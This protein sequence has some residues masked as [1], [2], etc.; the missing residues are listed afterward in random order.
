MRMLL[1]LI[2]LL[3]ALLVVAWLV[4]SQWYAQVGVGT[5]PSSGQEGDRSQSASAALR[6]F[7]QSLDKAL[8]AR[9]ASAA[10]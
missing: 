9:P 4:R 10:E 1:G 3:L 6:Q 2:G 5:P 8:K 7:K